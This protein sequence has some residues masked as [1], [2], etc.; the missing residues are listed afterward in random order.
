MRRDLHPLVVLSPR[1]FNERTGV[2][3]AVSRDYATSA[4]PVTNRADAVFTF[5]AAP[6]TGMTNQVSQHGN[7]RHLFDC[8]AVRGQLTTV[9]GCE[10]RPLGA[11][12]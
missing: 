5:N 1:E 12:L 4:A 9:V 6:A 2:M 11:V 7:A 3:G 10:L 8:V